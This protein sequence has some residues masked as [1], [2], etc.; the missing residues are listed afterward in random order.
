MAHLVESTIESQ[1]HELALGCLSP[2]V[3][4]HECRGFS[5]SKSPCRPTCMARLACRALE[6]SAWCGADLD[7]SQACSRRRTSGSRLGRYGGPDFI[8]P[9]RKLRN[10]FAFLAER[11]SG[12]KT[13][14]VCSSPLDI[15]QRILGGTL[16][17]GISPAF[18]RPDFSPTIKNLRRRSCQFFGISCVRADPR[19]CNFV[20][21]WWRLR[22]SHRLF[23]LARCGCGNRAFPFRQTPRS[24]ES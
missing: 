24:S 10:H 7:C 6:D 18:L 5:G 8:A 2:G 9:L 22:A 16:E 1:S 13:Y 19:F 12:R 4:R 3:A 17:S 14:Y 21:G 23:H 15:S 20:P 11:R